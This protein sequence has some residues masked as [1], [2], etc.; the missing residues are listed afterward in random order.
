VTPALEEFLAQAP[1][2]IQPD[3]FVEL[4]HLDLAYRREKGMTPTPAEYLARFPNF[5]ETIREAFDA[6]PGSTLAPRSTPSPSPPPEAEF[7]PRIGD[8]EL[9][10]E[11]GRGGMG[12]VFR[13]RQVSLDRLV[14]L[15]V[16]RGDGIMADEYV[17]RFQSEARAAGRLHHPGIV[18]VYDVGRDGPYHFFSMELIEGTT[19]ADRSEGALPTSDEAAE[20]LSHVAAAVH[21]AHESGILHRDLKPSNILIDRGGHVRIADFGLAKLLAGAETLTGTGQVLGTPSYMAPE[22][23]RGEQERIDRRCDVYSLGAVLYTLLTG[24]PPFRGRSPIDTLI[25]VVHETPRPP[26]ELNPAVAPALERICLKCLAKAPDDRYQSAE[27]LRAAMERFLSRSPADEDTNR[28]STPGTTPGVPSHS[29]V[30][31]RRIGLLVGIVLVGSITIAMASA[32]SQRGARNSPAD[33]ESL[34]PSPSAALTPTI[35]GDSASDKRP[36]APART[37]PPRHPG[38]PD[39]TF[40]KGG[41]VQLA[42]GQ[43]GGVNDAYAVALQQDGRIVVA[44]QSTRARDTHYMALTRHLPDGR[45]DPSFNTTGKMVLWLGAFD[46][47]VTGRALL[48]QPD[49]RIVF[50]GRG[51][52]TT[53]RYDFSLVRLN[54]NGTLDESFGRKGV[55]TTNVAGYSTSYLQA[56]ALQPDGKIMAAGNAMT[57]DTEIVFALVRYLP[58]GTLDPTFGQN[59]QALVNFP[60]ATEEVAGVAIRDDGGIA[61]AGRAGELGKIDAVIMVQNPDG[62][63]DREF[64]TGGWV[65]FDFHELQDMA[66]RIHY[67]GRKLLVQVGNGE[68]HLIL[69]LNADGRLDPTFGPDHDG[70]VRFKSEFIGFA[71]NPDGRIIVAHGASHQITVLSADGLT[72][73]SYGTNSSAP[74]S[75]NDV[76]PVLRDMVLAPDGKVVLCGNVRTGGSDCDWFL[77]RMLGPPSIGAIGPD[78]K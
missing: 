75:E 17:R 70:I 9:I 38:A 18:K 20:L 29:S 23:A 55:V 51:E 36:V 68:D 30:V 22:Q 77:L 32:L 49:G 10:G 73:E 3:A 28:S 15:K 21:A 47:G 74:V 24:R 7:P 66:S 8:Y 57:S 41:S 56:M 59:G 34:T 5:G 25:Q 53:I 45:L 13:A 69:R 12:V 2:A 43:G 71:L 46:D 14:A 58:D 48:I 54:E 78:S 76:R 4:L 72:L 40:G 65:R 39:P 61:W 42:V 64:G 6:S 37:E 16:I 62:T 31:M 52:V 60:G 33:L 11:L 27:S 67:Q 50:G 26:Q 35:A 63:P 19:L 1:T 44:G